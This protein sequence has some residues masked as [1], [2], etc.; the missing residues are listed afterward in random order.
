MGTIV[1][2]RG[3]ITIPKRIREALGLKPGSEVEF[4]VEEGRIVIR[5]AGA[6]RGRRPGRKDRFTRAR[7]CATI[8]W[9][10]DQLMALLRGGE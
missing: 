2:S 8:P 4:D 7:G 5:R 9:R 3:R 10:T 1:T 6:P